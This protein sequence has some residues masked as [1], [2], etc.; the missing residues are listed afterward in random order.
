MSLA[1]ARDGLQRGCPGPPPAPSPSWGGG[2]GGGT[3][4]LP[5]RRTLVFLH[6]FGGNV[7]Q[8]RRQLTHFSV[9]NRVISL[10][11]RGHG[12][13]GRT[14]GPFTTDQLLRDGEGGLKELRAPERAALVGHSF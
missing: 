8:W 14:P 6:G 4:S 1:I 11:L 9:D 10:G 7:S 13:G 2:G 12:V 3:L 5:P